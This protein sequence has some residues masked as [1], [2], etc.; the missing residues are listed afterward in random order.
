MKAKLILELKKRLPNVSATVLGLF[1]DKLSTKITDE[2]QIETTIDEFEASSP[3]SISDYADFIQRESDRRVTD[4][5]KKSKGEK[6]KTTTETET[7]VE[8]TDDMP[9]WAKALVAS[10]QSLAQGLQAIQEG[11][12]AT[13]RREQ[14]AK[15]LDGTSE[16][17]KAKALKDF[18][19]MS[20]QD[21]DNFN[22]F[23]VDA[24]E[25]AK[26]FAQEEANGGLGGDRPNGG[27][28]GAQ[29]AKK[30]ATSEEVDALV[31]AII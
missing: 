5:V 23:L 11:K 24:A 30:E 16:A 10:T 28:G 19:R 18:D 13:T 12:V 26:A 3:I 2:S 22:S 21:D 17:F 7:K 1:A 20:F 4:A 14:Y 8:T 29:N 9:A 6:T 27:V 25:D 15:T 31:D